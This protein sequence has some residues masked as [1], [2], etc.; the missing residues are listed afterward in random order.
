MR[1]QLINKQG[2]DWF[3]AD[4]NKAELCGHLIKDKDNNCQFFNR[5]CD[6][7]DDL[8]DEV[9]E[10]PLKFIFEG[11]FKIKA[12]SKE[13]AE[14]FVL[15]HCGLVIGGDIHSSLPDDEVDWKF[16]N[17]PE[18]KVGYPVTDFVKTRK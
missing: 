16:S 13:Q 7:L 5:E 4:A 2:C 10:I 1:N 11:I 8:E 3:V 14:E 18:K 6:D 12:Q 9:F 15:K 17:H